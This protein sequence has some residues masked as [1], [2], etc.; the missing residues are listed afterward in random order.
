M[1]KIILIVAM[2]FLFTTYVHAQGSRVTILSGKQLDL[3]NAEATESATI[4]GIV[5][6]IVESTPDLTEPA[7]PA[8]T[9]LERV[10]EENPV[11][12]L[13]WNNF[14]RYTLFRAVKNGVP[15]NTIIL[16]LLFPLVASMVVASRHLIG[17]QGLG[18]F[19]PSLLAIGFLA[20]GI[21]VGV[22]LFLSILLVATLSRMVLRRLKL[23]YLPRIA[24]LLWFVSLGV[25]GALAVAGSIG[26]D[27]LI[28]VGIFPILILMLLAESFIDVQVGRSFREAASLMTT[29]FILAIF[30]SYIISLFAVQKA[31][32]LRP[33]IVFFGVGVFDYFMAKYV[34]I[35]FIEYFKFR[36]ILVHSQ[37]EEE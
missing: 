20:T 26:Y 10:L 17:L 32:L 22:L 25:F 33:E 21:D 12:S 4:S 37:E 13:R 11:E 24:L 5:E 9:Q 34:G 8:K 23:Q 16:V 35:R 7:S 27:A 31:V 28:T 3:N 30:T 6:R 1:K 2:I 36:T 18:I 14:L 29:T 19:T 15:V